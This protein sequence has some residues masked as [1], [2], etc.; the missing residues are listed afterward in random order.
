MGLS[1]LHASSAWPHGNLIFHVLLKR[2]VSSCGEMWTGVEGAANR[3]RV[4]A[5]CAPWPGYDG[6]KTPGTRLARNALVLLSARGHG[7]ARK[8][9]IKPVTRQYHG[10]DGG[11]RGEDAFALA[12][13][14]LSYLCCQQQ[15]AGFARGGPSCPGLLPA[16]RLYWNTSEHQGARKNLG[17]LCG[18]TVLQLYLWATQAR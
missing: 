6:E 2:T 1:L 14:D 9:P 13:A 18:P 8:E 15:Q 11:L 12:K 7:I 4:N 16:A 10:I 17:C 3:E 5:C